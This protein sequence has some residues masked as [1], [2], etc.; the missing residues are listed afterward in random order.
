MG[1]EKELLEKLKALIREQDNPDSIEIGTPS[2]GGAVK[3][4]MNFSDLE[5][6]KKKIDNA[7]EVREYGAKLKE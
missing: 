5:A 1:D 6:C 4:Y 3:I 2:K 7:K